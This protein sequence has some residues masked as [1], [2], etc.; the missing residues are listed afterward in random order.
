[1]TDT[2][3]QKIINK[4]I[5]ADIIY[6]DEK[7]LVFRDINP[8]APTHLLIIPKKQI[9]KIS[10]ANEEDQDLLGHLFLVA[11]KVAKEL[12]IENAF[13]LVVNNGAGAQQTVFHLHI[14][15]LAEREFSWP[16]G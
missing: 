5:N 10:D 1:M 6:E 4:E 2:I 16:P 7:S 9:E 12:G 15:L 13:R 14:H 3:F 11:G 8:V